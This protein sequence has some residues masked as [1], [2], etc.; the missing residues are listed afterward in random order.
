[1]LFCGQPEGLALQIK[2]IFYTICLDKQKIFYTVCLEYV[3]LVSI[4]LKEE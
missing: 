2:Q 1:M 3:V 4:E